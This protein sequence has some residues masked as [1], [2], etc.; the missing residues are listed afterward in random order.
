MKLTPGM[1]QYMEIK[2]QNP[3]AIC[4]FRMGDFYE[5]FYEDA[6]T[7]ARELNIVLT[8]RGKG[9]TRAPLAGIPYHALEQYLAKLIRKGYKVAIVEQLED[10]K[11]AKGL[12][13]RG[14]VRIVTPGTIIEDCLLDEKNNNYIFSIIKDKD[15]F[16]IAIADISTGE[17]LT[18]KAESMDKVISELNR[19][20]P[21]ECIIPLSQ[22]DSDWAKSISQL[23]TI[24][25]GYDDR[26]Y[27]DEKSKETI[28]EHF[29]VIN[30]EGFGIAN[31]EEMISASGALI[32]Y[33]IETQKT[34]LSHIN[35]IK[36]FNDSEFMVLDA[37]TQ[38]NLELMSNIRENS[39][40]GTLISILDKTK[41]PMGSRLMK[42]W[43][44]RPLIEI[45]DIKKR[46][47]A[48]EEL[49]DDRIKQEDIRENLRQILDIERLISRISYGSANARDLNALQRSLSFIPQIKRIIAESSSEILKNIANMDGLDNIHDIINKSIEDDP[50][51]SLREGN[52]IKAE[53]DEELKKL[54]DI[55]KNGKNYIASLEEKE[56]EKTGIKSLKIKYNRVFGYFIEVTKSNLHLVPQEYIRKQTQANCERYI[57]DELK[58]QEELILGAE[59]KLHILEYNIFQAI[60]KQIAEQTSKIQQTAQSIAELDVIVNL[61]KIA[62]DN[63]YTKPFINEEGN[64]HIIDSRHPVLETLEDIYIPND[65]SIDTGN[66]IQIITGPNMAGKSSYMRQAALIIIMAQI[67][68][69][70]PAAKA[71]ICTVDRIFTRVGAY[72]DLTM[73]QSTFMVEMTETANILNNATSKSF[74]VLDEIGRGTSTYDGVSLA[75][76][77]AE[78]IHDNIKAKTLFATHYHQMNKLA[79]KLEGIRNYN[80]AVREKDDKI[81]F[82]RKIIEGSTDKS[83]GIQV[84]KLAGVPVGV[85]D[86]SKIIMTRLEMED[87]IG[88]KIHAELK[89]KKKPVPEDKKK[90]KEKIDNSVQKSL[91][92]I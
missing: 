17:F 34:S 20:R 14:L 26:H 24:I 49:F 86:R 54:K 39:L 72:D 57:T 12:V 47:E 19:F 62:A 88:E 60:I 40:R 55:T 42:K 85:I 8:A 79:E 53:Y 21:S 7:V 64:I 50:P 52:L 67:G 77:I 69:F 36:K 30:L 91:L 58:K 45:K 56:Q 27:W 46:Q 66:F 15:I 13:K 90:I 28:K 59:E 84:A 74:I 11:K 76:A 78:Y 22:E 81:I 51:L 48:V 9:E 29:N 41:T 4:L 1:R 73:G 70:I 2:N 5:T 25:S 23:G 68:S 31:E 87:E 92:G 18:S 38:R 75:W 63:N 6:K 83:Y 43:L 71:S 16:G 37:S 10:P 61:A 33:L 89:T 3:D 35:K 80:I 44:L 65:I 32:S 82:L